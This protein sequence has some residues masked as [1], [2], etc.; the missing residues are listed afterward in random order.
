MSEQDDYLNN[1]SASDIQRFQLIEIIA[2]WEGRL[3]TNHL[4]SVFQLG[5]QQASRFINQYTA[6]RPFNLVYDQSVR[7]Y[8]TTEH[9]RPVFTR[10]RVDEYLNL[11]K[12][13]QCLISK[14]NHTALN[15]REITTVTPPPR[16]IKS[17]VMRIIGRAIAVN[18]EVEIEYTSLTNPEP[19]TLIISPHSLI[20]TP[21]RWYVRAYCEESK[22]YSD[23]VLSRITNLK[24][25]GGAS[26]HLED[27]ENWCTFVDIILIPN[28]EFSEKQRKIIEQDYEMQNGELVIP[29]RLSLV[30]YTLASLGI[31]LYSEG[32]PPNKA[33][34][35][36]KDKEKLKSYLMS[37]IA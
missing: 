22:S 27:D 18:K 21:L 28:I 17:K 19:T 11:L 26:H 31:D 33:L 23:I 9:F 5:R 6:L 4:G 24:L 8:K 30:N 35:Q 37:D 2:Y 15:M 32:Q 3:T 36:P 16:F 14:S 10:G 29:T 1:L 7:G 13:N 20:E 25:L 12:M 34:I